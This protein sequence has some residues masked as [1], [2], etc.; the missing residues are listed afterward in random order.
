MAQSRCLRG[1]AGPGS[2]GRGLT[3]HRLIEGLFGSNQ[4]LNAFRFLKL[5]LGK[6]N[7]DIDIN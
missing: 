5:K 6:S 2:A 1:R 3:E 7:E 4:T